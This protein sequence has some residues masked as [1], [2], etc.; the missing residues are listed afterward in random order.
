MAG[1]EA[2]QTA[3][4]EP[5]LLFTK[6]DCFYMVSGILCAFFAKDAASVSELPPLRG[7][8]EIIKTFLRIEKSPFSIASVLHFCYSYGNT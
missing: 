6:P 1:L 5:N 4:A 2:G 8:E 3:F 7:L